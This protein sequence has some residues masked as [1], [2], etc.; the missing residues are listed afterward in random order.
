MHGS[1]YSIRM[2]VVYCTGVK[3]NGRVQISP[4]EYFNFFICVRKFLKNHS[5]KAPV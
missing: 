5:T 1:E 2:T 4:L 3:F